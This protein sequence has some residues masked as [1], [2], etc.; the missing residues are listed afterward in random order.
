MDSQK[1]NHVAEAEQEKSEESLDEEQ[2]ESEESS[3][4][5]DDVSPTYTHFLPIPKPHPLTPSPTGNQHNQPH[6]LLQPLPRKRPVPLLPKRRNDNYPP[7]IDPLPVGPVRN[8]LRNRLVLL[9]VSFS[10]VYKR[11]YG[12]K[13]QVRG[14]QEGYFGKEFG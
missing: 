7:L 3:S 9:P 14:M 1:N 5:R 11:I 6:F 13:A 4:S 10:F 8:F 12:C 2:E